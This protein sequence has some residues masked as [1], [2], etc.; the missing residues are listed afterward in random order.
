MKTNW[1]LAKRLDYK[2]RFTKSWVGREEKEAI[3]LVSVPVGGD[4]EEEWAYMGLE[5][6]PGEWGVWTTLGTAILGADTGKTSL[7]A[8][9]KASETNSRAVR[10][11]YPTCEEW[12]FIPRTRERKQ[13]ET[14][15]GSG[16]LPQSSS[17]TMCP[18]SQWAP[19]TEL[20]ALAQLPS[21]VKSATSKESAQLGGRSRLG[22]STESE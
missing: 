16:C 11:L 15:W 2:E 14:A 4:T 7:L 9:L 6:L 3:R 8:D 18:N 1:R 17:S 21:R 20:P 22:S 12:L 10:N 13:N 5:I 19:A